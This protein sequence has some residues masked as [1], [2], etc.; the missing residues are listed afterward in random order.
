MSK[1]KGVF[2]GGFEEISKVAAGVSASVA[3]T[4]KGIDRSGVISN[5]SLY[6]GAGGRNA[7]PPQKDAQRS[8]LQV[9]IEILTSVLL[10]EAQHML[11]SQRD[12]KPTGG[13]GGGVVRFADGHV[14]QQ[15]EAEQSLASAEGD[16]AVAVEQFTSWRGT[17]CAARTLNLSPTE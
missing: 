17:T 14:E 3:Q 9:V 16:K 2:A 15:S 6:G 4:T 13:G 1:G 5:R 12:G 10:Q 11:K 7:A 8:H